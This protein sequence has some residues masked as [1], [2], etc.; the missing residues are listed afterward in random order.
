M[1]PRPKCPGSVRALAKVVEEA[2]AVG[3]EVFEV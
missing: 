1:G 3:G 2:G